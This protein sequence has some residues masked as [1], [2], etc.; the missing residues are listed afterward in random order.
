MVLRGAGQQQHFHL[1]TTGS[2]I[3]VGW[4]ENEI[5]ESVINR[6]SVGEEVVRV[7]DTWIVPDGKCGCLGIEWRLFEMRGEFVTA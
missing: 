1:R 6:S 3:Q 5:V 4:S 7:V 2:W